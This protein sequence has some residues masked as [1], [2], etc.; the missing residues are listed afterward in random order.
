MCA[1]DLCSK[2]SI[3][4]LHTFVK[5]RFG[6]LLNR[7]LG[8]SAQTPDNPWHLFE[9]HMTIKQTRQGKCYKDWL[10]ARLVH[11][12]D[13]DI[14][15]LEGG[16][17]LII[18]DVVRE[19]LR[20]ECAKPQTVSLDKALS[21]EFSDF[22]LLDLLASEQSPINAICMLEYERL[23]D[24]YAEELIQNLTDRESIALLAKYMG[25]S[26]VNPLVLETAECKKTVFTKTYVKFVQKVARRIKTEYAEEDTQSLLT[27]TLMVL[28]KIKKLNFEQKKAEQPLSSLFMI[29]DEGP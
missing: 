15:V 2:D 13:P 5:L 23:A 7:G 6:K 4:A 26:L 8:E 28:R 14:N 21:G 3:S 17:T 27:L 29:E 1:L 20:Q 9:A 24:S 11:S 25:I 16:A 12:A 22:T 10:F 18:R 19:Y